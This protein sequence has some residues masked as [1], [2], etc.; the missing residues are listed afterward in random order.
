M[1]TANVPAP[2]RTSV[3]TST[4]RCLGA[5]AVSIVFAFA[6]A[7]PAAPATA[8]E[9]T[10]AG[11]AVARVAG[12]RGTSDA[13]Q[14]EPNAAADPASHGWVHGSSTTRLIARSSDDADDLDLRE[15]LALDFGDAK[16]DRF[17]GHVFGML[18]ADLDGAGDRDDEIAFPSL[19]DTFS[20]SVDAWLYEAYVDVAQVDGLASLRIGRQFDYETPEF[21]HFDG[22]ALAT[23]EAGAKRLRF[24]AY[25]GVPVHLYESSHSGDVLFGA[26]GECWPWARGR[27]RVDWMHLEDE[28]RFAAHDNDLVG[29][30]L[31]QRAGERL[32]LE[33]RYTNLEGEDRDVRL[34]A[35]W[36]DAKHDFVVRATWH[37][38]L[39]T[40]KDLV[41]ELDPFYGALQ[42]LYPYDQVDVT[43]E[44][45]VAGRATVRG[46]VDVRRVDDDGDIGTFNRDYDRAF[47]GATLHDVFGSG[48]ELDVDVDTWDADGRDV[49]GWGVSVSRDFSGACEA[50]LGTYYSLYKFDLLSA[51]EREDVRT[52]FVKLRR[53]WSKSL[54]GEISYDLDD[55]E[56]D[57]FQTL[58]VG[59]T[60]RF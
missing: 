43:V 46:G 7:A 6:C 55:E 2:L 54:R 24:G 16:T 48:V 12:E 3:R 32:G 56:N 17:T 15:S 18:T 37:R 38:L 29:L 14:S 42:S 47:G 51:T 10:A 4:L 28:T 39:S 23:D 26:F 50:S 21:A 31:W 40:Q 20:G 60:W 33:G 22:V 53:T 5:S 57:T 36:N 34:G 59:F 1:S 9:T 35:S 27:A 58:R 11:L 19:A 25:G 41:L 49:D 52:W 44:K 8:D 13:T 45:G 30:S